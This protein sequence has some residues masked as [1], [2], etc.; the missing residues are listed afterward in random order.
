MAKWSKDKVVWAQRTVY[1][2]E[3]VFVPSEKAFERYLKTERAR[4]KFPDYNFKYPTSNARTTLI[5]YPKDPTH[6]LV[7]LREDN[8]AKSNVLNTLSS[9]VHEAVHV[10]DYIMEDAGE[11]KPSAEEKAYTIQFIF[12]Q[13]VQAYILSRKPKFGGVTP[14]LDSMLRV[15]KSYRPGSPKRPAAAGS[16][17][18]AQRRR[19]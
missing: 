2:S 3:I 6:I 12:Q 9:L 4:E 11:E 18:R 17:A 7:F 15:R 8:D 1:A 14:P 16:N 19:P 5:D 13:L 10:F